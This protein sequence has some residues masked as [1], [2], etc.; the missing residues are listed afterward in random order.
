MNEDYYPN[1]TEEFFSYVHR[2]ILDNYWKGYVC[3]M[4]TPSTSIL[5]FSGS[6]KLQQNTPLIQSNYATYVFT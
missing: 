4:T 3:N 1:L 6:V 2:V 5:S